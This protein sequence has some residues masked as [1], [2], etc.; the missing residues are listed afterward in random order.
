MLKDYL[1]GIFETAQR[2]DARE[3][4]YYP[5]LKALLEAVAH[6]SGNARAHVTV[7]PKKTEAGNPDFRV[8]DGKQ[9]ITGYLE[10]KKPTEEN[11]K[12]IEGS[13]QLKRY[14]N[15]FPN[16]ILTNF[17][18]FR[19]YRN[20]DLIDTVQIGR[21]FIVHKL[22][23]VPPVEK[24]KEFLNL[25]EKFFSFSLPKTYSAKSLA[26]ELAKRTR[27][28]KE[29]ITYEL[30]VGESKN[31]LGFYEAFQKFL[32]GS[33]TTEDFVNLYA[34]TITYGL[35]AARTRAKNGFNRKLAYDLIP[36]TI[37]ILRDV[38]DFISLGDLPPQMEWVVDDIAEVLSV[39]DI[40]K[41]LKDRQ[42]RDPIVHFYEPFLAEYDPAERERRGVYYTPEPVVSYIVRSLHRVLKDVFDRPDGFASS[43]VRVL[44]PAAG[45]CTFPAEAARQAVN[46]FVAKYGEG[47]KG[48]LIP[49]HILKNFYAFELMMAPYAVGHLKI[50]YLLEELGHPLQ[51]DERFQLYLT[52]T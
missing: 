23:I 31:I 50:G 5:D 19:L 14:R 28:L 22:K 43:S 30:R 4:S 36:Q 27:F 49:D 34:Q 2:G 48:Q 35:F 42:G 32:I 47:A 46:E 44:D 13:E 16:L 17:F 18:E 1:K 33:L 29:L 11:L 51:K 52:N 40:E 8:W 38:F 7:L 3:K 10:A 45:T 37:G 25:F 26:V 20:G 12:Y 6:S 39:A 41:I 24:K 15:T 21:P 9:H